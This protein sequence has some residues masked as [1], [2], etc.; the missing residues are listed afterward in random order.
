MGEGQDRA[1]RFRQKGR[2]FGFEVREGA[3]KP[4]E[5]EY[6]SRDRAGSCC[7]SVPDACSSPSLH[8][9][10]DDGSASHSLTDREPSL[11]YQDQAPCSPIL[12]PS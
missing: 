3:A 7:R 1:G 2:I 4:A 8:D 10:R 5:T 12:M 6:A 9:G 11:I